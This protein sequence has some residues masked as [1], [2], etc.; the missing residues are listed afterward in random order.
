MQLSSEIVVWSM[1][2][3]KINYYHAQDPQCSNEPCIDDLIAKH[4][5]VV[6]LKTITYRNSCKNHVQ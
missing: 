6:P 4:M 1:E 5:T 3:L 2:N